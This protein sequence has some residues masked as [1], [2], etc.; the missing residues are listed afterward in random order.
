MLLF[1]LIL[2]Q[3][4][5][6]ITFSVDFSEFLLKIRHLNKSMNKFVKCKK[7]IL[8]MKRNN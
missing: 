6:H 2:C 3:L 5:V 8:M 4:I 1:Y 7:F